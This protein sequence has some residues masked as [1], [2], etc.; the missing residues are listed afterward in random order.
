MRPGV[1]S[2]RKLLSHV[3]MQSDCGKSI[4]H[5][6]TAIDCIAV[7]S[8]HEGN[9]PISQSLNLQSKIQ[10]GSLKIVIARNEANKSIYFS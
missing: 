3:A 5:D 8:Q 2:V 9:L 10:Y 1:R 6:I 7:R 4:A